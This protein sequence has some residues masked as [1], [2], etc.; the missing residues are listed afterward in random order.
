MSPNVPETGELQ[1]PGGG[2]IAISK[3]FLTAGELAPIRAVSPSSTGLLL[4]L[5][6][7]TPWS[8]GPELTPTK[9]VAMFVRCVVPATGTV[10]DVSVL[11]ASA[12]GEVRGAIYDTGEA[13]EGEY[14]LLAQSTAEAQGTASKWQSLGSFSELALHAGQQIMLGVMGSEEGT[15]FWASIATASASGSRELPASY[16]AGSVKPK[17]VGIKKFASLAFS[18]TLTDAEMAGSTV[19]GWAALIGRVS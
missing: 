8:T 7:P 12:T 16:L 17:L 15:K 14:S 5:I 18:A 11:N 19:G 4:P 6:N 3:G 2:S 13:A 9:F 1:I 10:K